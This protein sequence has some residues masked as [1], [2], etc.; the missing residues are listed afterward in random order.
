MAS[1]SLTLVVDAFQV[2]RL[3]SHCSPALA[4]QDCTGK[5]FVAAGLRLL[6]RVDMDRC[7]RLH[8]TRE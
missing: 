8:F 4:S 3:A 7:D 5:F 2:R 1:A 6:Q